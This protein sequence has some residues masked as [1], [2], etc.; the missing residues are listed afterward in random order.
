[1]SYQEV[2][3]KK[4]FIARAIFNKP[5]ILILDEAT[6]S[7]DALSE[8]KIMM[9][10]KKKFVNSTIIVVTHRMSIL[11]F[12]D[13]IYFLEKGKVIENG[14]WSELYNNKNSFLEI[15]QTYKK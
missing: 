12:T 5:K 2:K 1:M 11:K 15:W 9:Q 7:Q 10:L 6:S 13:Q 8:K 3:Y 4:F 14:T